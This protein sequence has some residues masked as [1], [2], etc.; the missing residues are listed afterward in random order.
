MQKGKEGAVSAY[1]SPEDPWNLTF[2]EAN[3]WRDRFAAVP[4]EHKGG[5]F[6]PRYF[7]D[8]AIDRVLEA[9]ASQKKRIL[10]TLATG[11]GKTFIAFQIAWKLFHARWNLSGQPTRRLRTLFLSDRKILADQAYNAFSAFAEDA[12]VRIDP[13]DIRKKSHV[14]KNGSLFSTIFQTFMSGPSTK[15]ANQEIGVP[16][17]GAAALHTKRRTTPSFPTNGVGAHKSRKLALPAAGRR[18]ETER[19]FK[20]SGARRDGESA[21]PTGRQALR[22]MEPS[23]RETPRQQIARRPDRKRRGSLPFCFRA[24][25]VSTFARRAVASSVQAGATFS[26]WGGAR[27]RPSFRPFGGGVRCG[28]GLC[29]RDRRKG[30]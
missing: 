1:A 9:I 3:E 14:P 24:S 2:A 13:G 29:A 7:Q 10:L 27:R 17:E 21:L 15:T 30:D 16:R 6:Q 26:S 8:I 25:R 20:G 4:F 28:G 23:N 11:T 5:Y 18:Y 19:K 12:P 22:K